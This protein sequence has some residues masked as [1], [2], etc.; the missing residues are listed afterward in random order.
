MTSI[1]VHQVLFDEMLRQRADSTATLFCEH[2]ERDTCCYAVSHAELETN[3]LLKLSAKLS[4]LIGLA[5]LLRG[6]PY[7]CKICH[8]VVYQY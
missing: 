7:A 5:D 4:E 6:R 8:Y 1:R 3:V 2:C